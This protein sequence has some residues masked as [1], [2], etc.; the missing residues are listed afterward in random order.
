MNPR[1]KNPNPPDWQ[2]ERSRILQRACRRIQRSRARGQKFQTILPRVARHYNGKPFKAVPGR[3]LRLSV[4]T[5]RRLWLAWKSRAEDAA[6]FELHFRPGKALATAPVM[7]SLADYCAAQRHK[8]MREA[9]RAFGLLPGNGHLSVNAVYWSACRYIRVKV[10]KEMQEHLAAIT[11]AQ[12]GLHQLRLAA[13][14]SIRARL[15]DT[16]Q[17]GSAKGGELI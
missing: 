12:A 14:A 8:S 11:T 9:C 16:I 15:P 4:S 2:A 1:S 7:V 17:P 10:F 13:A 5:L 3:R 6:V